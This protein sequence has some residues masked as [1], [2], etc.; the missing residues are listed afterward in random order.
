MTG[1]RAMCFRLSYLFREPARFDVIAFEGQK[2]GT[3]WVYLKRIIGLPG[4]RLEI[5]DGWVFVDDSTTP[6]PEQ[7]VV[8]PRGGNYGPFYIPP[9][10]YFVLGDNRLAS[11][12]SKNWDDPFLPLDR[13]LG[14]A[15][16]A[17][18]PSI[19]RI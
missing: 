9:S 4:E 15:V 14:R 8:G 2:P 13:I 5:R 17:Y 10:H 1:D 16:F 7:F 11:Y 6:L 3:S 18:W 19:G 12:D